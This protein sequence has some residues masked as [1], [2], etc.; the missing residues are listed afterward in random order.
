[1][2][3]FYSNMKSIALSSSFFSQWRGPLSAWE[4]SLWVTVA[5]EGVLWARDGP[6][7]HHCFATLTPCQ[8][9]R[10]SRWPSPLK[11]AECSKPICIY[12]CVSGICMNGL[13]S[14]QFLDLLI[15]GQ[16]VSQ[17]RNILFITTASIPKRYIDKS[18]LGDASNH[19]SLSSA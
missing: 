17:K 4:G 14:Y 13:R 5:S 18:Q 16:I 7:S 6:S 9:Q 2:G 8:T 1:M 15:V 11:I 3:E 12:N 19:I 10:H